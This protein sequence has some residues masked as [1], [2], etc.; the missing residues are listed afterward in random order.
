MVK[1]ALA[2]CALTSLALWL[3]AFG[4]AQAHACSASDTLE[5]NP[6][7]AATLLDRAA[8]R[9]GGMERLRAISHLR[10]TADGLVTNGLQG[11][12]PADV[13]AP[14][15]QR[16]FTRQVDLDFFAHRHRVQSSLA[17]DG[18]DVVFANVFADGAVRTTSL[19]TG[20]TSSHPS[21]EAVFTDSLARYAPALLLRR[22]N[23]NAA[24]TTPT[25]A[26]CLSGVL[27]DGVDFWWNDTVHLQLF[28][29]RDDQRLVRLEASSADPLIGRAITSYDFIGEQM[30]DGI[31]FPE[32][33]IFSRR[34]VPFTDAVLVYD[35][36][37]S[38][39][40]HPAPEHLIET[41]A[42]GPAYRV[43]N[44][45]YEMPLGGE[46]NY[47]HFFGRRRRRVRRASRQRR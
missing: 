31:S 32:R 6:M 10:F 28:L 40:N 42:A 39:E 36:N 1:T 4:T 12:D 17:F 46:D 15:T 29:D 33:V 26:R 35:L 3:T 44:G 43:G 41:A 23:E 13:D 8:T 24:T 37:P 7:S 25:G 27:A 38:D 5:A 16:A 22:A 14:R 45:V 9:L 47:A 20:A 34:G 11:R 2:R 19:S 21:T 18:A 30:V